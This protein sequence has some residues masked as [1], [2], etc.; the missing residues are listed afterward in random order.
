MIPIHDNCEGSPVSPGVRDAVE[1]LLEALPPGHLAGLESVVLSNSMAVGKGKT[2]RVLGRKYKRNEC[3]GFYHPASDGSAAW[4]EL[5]VDRILPFNLPW[6]APRKLILDMLFSKTLYH[7]VGHHLDDTIGSP[8]R[9][10]ERAAD[11]WATILRKQYFRRHHRVATFVLRMVFPVFRA[12]AK[13][14]FTE[15]REITKRKNR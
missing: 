7:E 13:N 3:L 5:V 14:R 15:A 12:L 2:S 11:S 8:A 1:R 4:V 6:W 10:G 9:T